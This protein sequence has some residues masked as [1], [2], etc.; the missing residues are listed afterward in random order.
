METQ[1]YS[2]DIK[3]IINNANITDEILKEKYFNI[4]NDN[5]S[6]MYSYETIINELPVRKYEINPDD[7][8]KTQQFKQEYNK[9]MDIILKLYSEKY[10]RVFQVVGKEN[11][12]LFKAFEELLKK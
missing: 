9:Q 10:I 1:S 11:I 7:D 8:N 6:S 5:Y 4:M 3:E 12:N 2:N